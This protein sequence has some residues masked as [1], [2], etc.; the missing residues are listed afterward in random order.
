MQILRKILT[1]QLSNADLGLSMWPLTEYDRSPNHDLL[2]LDH[3]GCDFPRSTFA[4]LA[5][6]SPT[7][8]GVASVATQF[9]LPRAV[10]MTFSEEAAF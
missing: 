1:Q 8:N 10:T 9:A 6:S 3:L 7:V 5:V 2:S 4:A